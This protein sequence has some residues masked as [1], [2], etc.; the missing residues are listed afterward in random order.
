MDVKIDDVWV[1]KRGTLYEGTRAKI[2]YIT[3]RYLQVMFD[4]PLH[5]DGMTLNGEPMT[6]RT[7]FHHFEVF[8]QMT[9]FDFLDG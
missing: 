2:E 4:P 6:K 3:P 7:F 1:G 8:H 5:I 9:I